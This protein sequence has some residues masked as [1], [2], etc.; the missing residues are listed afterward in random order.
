MLQVIK[1]A[2]VNYNDGYRSVHM[3][4]LDRFIDKGIGGPRT[5]F[6]VHSKERERET[7][8]LSVLLECCFQNPIMDKKDTDPLSQQTN[9]ALQIPQEVCYI[10]VLVMRKNRLKSKALAQ[11]VTSLHFRSHEECK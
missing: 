8:T 5:P 2:L 9:L 1:Y 11:I 10:R 3:Q 4:S 7:H 6:H